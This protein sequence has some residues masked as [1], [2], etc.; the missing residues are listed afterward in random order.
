MQVD[1]VIVA[2]SCFTPTPS[3]AAMIVNRFKMR[4][5]VQTYNLGG[6]GCS[7]SV[8]CLELSRQLLKVCLH[9][10]PAVH[11]GQVA[12]ESI[13]CSEHWLANAAC[14]VRG[15]RATATRG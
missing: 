11:D 8:L 6:M 3:L 13:S 15:C 9:T 10:S 5:D 7:S 2:C 12:C 1:A 4:A 14:V